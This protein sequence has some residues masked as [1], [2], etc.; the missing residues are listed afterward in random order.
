MFQKESALEKNRPVLEASK[1][2][3]QAK[4]SSDANLVTLFLDV[5]RQ[6]IKNA[7]QADENWRALVGSL[8]TLHAVNKPGLV[9]FY[10]KK[11][12]EYWDDRENRTSITNTL[13]SVRTEAMLQ[14]FLRTVLAQLISGEP[15]YTAPFEE[16]RMERLNAAT[17][18]SLALNQIQKELGEG[19]EVFLR[20]NMV[21]SM[22]MISAV[23]VNGASDLAG[24]LR[25]NLDKEAYFYNT[26]GS[27]SVEMLSIH[28]VEKIHIIC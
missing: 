28:T 4:L 25:E 17:T 19:S 16:E 13:R 14:T 20:T 9:A 2:Y 26:C 5:I 11:V 1:A 6:Q 23:L 10:Q 15:I 21:L 8:D 27:N 7:E 18:P 12:R 3:L 22:P 24:Y